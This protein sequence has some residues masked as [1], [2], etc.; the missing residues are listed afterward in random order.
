MVFS[1]G[2]INCHLY[3]H[4]IDPRCHGN[5]I[6]DEIGYN[7]VCVKDFCEIFAHIGGFSGMGHRM[8]PIAFSPTDPRCHDNEIRDKIIG[9]NSACV[10]DICEIF[11]I[12]VGVFGNGPSN[13][14]NWIL[15]PTTLVAMAT[16]FKTKWAL[17]RFVQQILPRSLHLTEMRLRVWQLDD[18]SRSL[19]QPALISRYNEQ[20]R[21]RSSSSSRHIQR[22]VPDRRYTALP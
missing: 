11:C 6:W 4:P 8:L 9:Y 14:A 10:I 19:P 21:S 20:Q 16:K 22:S 1:D 2:L 18:V 5:E 3:L 12:C 13:A 15:P 7:S 17:P